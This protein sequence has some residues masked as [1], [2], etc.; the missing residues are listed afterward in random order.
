MGNL[1]KNQQYTNKKSTKLIKL[2]YIIA[3]EK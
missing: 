3:S 2:S 1:H